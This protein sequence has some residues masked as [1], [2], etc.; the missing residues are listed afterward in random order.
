[1]RND[2]VALLGA[3]TCSDSSRSGFLRRRLSEP[4]IDKGCTRAFLPFFKGLSL[5]GFLLI[6]FLRPLQHGHH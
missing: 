3:G 6:R 1:M 5:F 2:R 4:R